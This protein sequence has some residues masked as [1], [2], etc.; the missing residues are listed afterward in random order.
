MNGP[1]QAASG[2]R[3]A[4]DYSVTEALD[5]NI[6]YAQEILQYSDS[7]DQ[8]F[9]PNR[10]NTL[11]QYWIDYMGINLRDQIKKGSDVPLQFLYEA[12]NCRIFYTPE[13]F[14]N[15]TALWNHAA[16]AT[17]TD[18]SLCVKGSTGYASTNGTLVP[19]PSSA[20]VEAPSTPSKLQLGDPSSSMGAIILAML[21]ASSSSIETSSITATKNTRSSHSFEGQDCSVHACAA[22][23]YCT[24]YSKSCSNGKPV[25]YKG[26]VAECKMY[27]GYCR[28]SGTCQ[29]VKKATDPK[30]ETSAQLKV[31]LG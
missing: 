11:G 8:N 30:K 10:T 7:S 22:D 3:G 25:K 26:C 23:Y 20:N 9:L 19:A 27:P 18:P 12:A 16:A 2:T 24:D 28:N 14:Y 1:M 17:W 29:P 31:T 13:T 21:G 5:N 15:Y 4:R 6:A